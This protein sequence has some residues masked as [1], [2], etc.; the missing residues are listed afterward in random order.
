MLRIITGILLTIWL[1][2]V[3]IGKGGFVHLLLLNALGVASVEVI[4]MYRSRV[5]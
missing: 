3:I 5:T 4:T 1:F 2:L